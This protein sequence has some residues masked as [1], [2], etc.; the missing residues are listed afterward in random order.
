MIMAVGGLTF[1][2]GVGLLFVHEKLGEVLGLLAFEDGSV[3]KV[4]DG[5]V[6]EPVLGLTVVLVAYPVP[7]SQ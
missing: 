2:E 6:A 3:E 7:K 5:A 1:E 4:Q